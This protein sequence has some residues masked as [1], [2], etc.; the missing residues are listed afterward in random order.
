MKTD[1]LGEDC[2]FYSIYKI[3][4]TIMIVLNMRKSG[5][6]PVSCI[7][8]LSNNSSRYII[9]SLNFICDFVSKINVE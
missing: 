9:V 8:I 3:L 4:N 7:S 6:S 5:I 2:H 1:F